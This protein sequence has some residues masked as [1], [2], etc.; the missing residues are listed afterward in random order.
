[1]CKHRASNTI[2]K[3]GYIIDFTYFFLFHGGMTVAK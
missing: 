3:S 2:Q 1:M